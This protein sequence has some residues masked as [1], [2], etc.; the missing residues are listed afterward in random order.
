MPAKERAI[1]RAVRNLA[2]KHDDGASDRELLARFVAQRDQDAF[3]TLVRRHGPMVMGVGLRVMHHHQDAEDV[4]QATFLLLAR[5]AKTTAWRDTIA[6]WLYEVAHNL[7]RKARDAAS[8]RS[9]HE[10][11]APVKAPTDALGEITLRDL[12]A[13]LDEE[14]TRLPKKYRAPILLCCLEGKARDEAA[15]CL[16][17]PLGLI[18]SRLE[19]GRELLRRRLAGRGL[20]LSVAL[21]GHTLLSE[22][23]RAAV[24]SLLLRA[25]GRAAL[26][27][28]AGRIDSGV[29]SP[30]VAALVNG[31]LR[32]MFLAK[33]KV[34]SIALLLACVT[35]LGTAALTAALTLQAAQGQSHDEGRPPSAPTARA[36]KVA[37]KGGSES[38]ISNDAAH[39]ANEKADADRDRRVLEGH[40][41]MVKFAAFSPNGKMFATGSLASAGGMAAD[42]VILWDMAAQKPKH[43]VTLKDPVTLYQLAFSPDGKT[44]AVGTN[45]GI[46]LRDAETGAVKGVLKGHRDGTGVFSLAFSPDGMVLAS[47]GSIGEETIRLWEVKT[48]Q[49]KHTLKGHTYEV[50][51]LTFSPDGKTLASAG[52]QK[53]ATIRLWDV[54]TGKA[55]LTVEVTYQ[56][57]AGFPLAFS[58]DGKILGAP[59]GG[60]VV[61]F[62]T[63]TGEVKDKLIKPHESGNTIEALAFS[64][65]G[66]LV[67]AGRESGEIDVWET[68]PAD[69]KYDWRAG[70]LKETLK[71]HRS[72]AMSIA[73]SPLGKVL[74]SGH[75]DSVVRLWRLMAAA[76]GGEPDQLKAGVPKAAAKGGSAG[77]FSNGA[78]Q[79]SKPAWREILT[80]KHEH[81]ITAIACSSDWSVAGDERGKLFAWDTKTGKNR[82]PLEGGGRTIDR[83]QFTA[84]EKDQFTADGK[85]LYVIWG[86]RMNIARYFRKD[87]KFE[88]GHGF[89]RGDDGAYLGVSADA[90]IRLELFRQGEAVNLRRNAYEFKMGA[91]FIRPNFDSNHHEYVEYKTKVSHALLSAGDKW[92]AVATKDGTLHIHDRASLKE[93]H[94]IASGKKGVVITDVQFSADGQRIAVARD[95]RLAKVYDT[96]KGEEVATL[97]GH[98]G[99]VFAIAFSADGNKVVTGGDDNTARIWD[100]ATGKALATLQGHTDSVR[101]AA[102]DASGEILVTGSAD[103]TVKLWTAN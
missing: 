28:L 98:S 80:M 77:A 87:K 25:T 19:E 16:G 46:E 69:A 52:G 59:H 78:A 13:V 85:S 22:T 27:A 14:L 17:W 88:G 81:P 92:L 70:D 42:E 73:F 60:W 34:T 54:E 93:T 102:F 94:T 10:N 82:T 71:G 49:L 66:K 45:R 100:A 18:K 72:G 6:N 96:A 68:R 24:P 2:Q 90:E 23:A 62:D 97:K 53:D 48:G 1:L 39:D 51:G 3:T 37:A 89:G 75:R 61:F 56:P 86:E 36:L 44:L 9:V 38:T 84:N 67:A 74:V 32:T 30:A 63:H 65:D 76:T 40:R 50:M 95:D 83:L 55:K 43:T 26:Q 8:R 35:G 31:G 20:L 4:C 5:K 99:I 11:R 7:A 41:G 91:F 15:R 101:C 79:D 103:K 57:W 21:A 64:P 58:P 47:G 33:L 12:K 29:V